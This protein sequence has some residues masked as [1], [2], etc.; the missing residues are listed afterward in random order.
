MISLHFFTQKYKSLYY[1][2]N[3]KSRV[4][5]SVLYPAIYKDV[6]EVINNVSSSK[7]KEVFKK[8]QYGNQAKD[9]L[10]DLEAKLKKNE[11]EYDLLFDKKISGEITDSDFHEGIERLK[12]K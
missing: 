9:S 1:C 10:L 4:F 5:T 8:R 3:C 2:L 11:A 6:E 12:K 7:F